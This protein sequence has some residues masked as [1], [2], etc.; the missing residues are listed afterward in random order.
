MSTG[1]TIKPSSIEESHLY[2]EKK[3]EEDKVKPEIK[4]LKAKD[5]R[6]K[7]LKVNTVSRKDKSPE[8]EKKALKQD[9]GLISV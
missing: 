2:T 6:K 4:R 1:Y 9:Q 5:Q 7:G 8:D 3:T